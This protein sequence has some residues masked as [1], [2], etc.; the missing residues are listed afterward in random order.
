MKYE[1]II[2]TVKEDFTSYNNFQ[3]PKSGQV[4]ADDFKPTS[5]C[6][7]GLHGLR[8]GQQKPGVWYDDGI[9]LLLQVP[10]S[11]IIDLNNNKCKFPEC[12]IV[13]SGNMN[14]ITNYLYKK[15][16]NIEGLYRRS[17]LSNK[18]EKWIGGNWSTLTAGYDSTLTA[19]DNSKLTAGDYSI[20]TAGDYS[21]L[22]AG[23]GSK[24]TA[25]DYSTLT[26][27]YG[28]TLTAGSDSILTAGHFS[29]LTAGNDSTLTAGDYSTL[30]AG[31]DSTLTAGYNSTLTAGD[32]S[33]LTAGDN[34]ALTAGDDSTLTAGDDSTLTAGDNST[35][36]AGDNS[37]LS[38]EFRDDDGKIKLATAYVGENDI[39]PN[40]AYK[41]NNKG[42]FY[43]V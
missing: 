5:E 35:L 14:E 4:K 16:I 12:K 34:S 10:A 17:Q 43:K 41:V 42:E 27:G 25:S 38:C 1:Y 18:S 6:G 13:M 23:D 31:S 37:R 29:T 32:N 40:Q 22:T 26:A 20:L 8:I 15:N 2:R 19:G 7:N 30:T 3:W 28:S 36:T 9:V 39:K 11:T 21:I 33:T 24:L